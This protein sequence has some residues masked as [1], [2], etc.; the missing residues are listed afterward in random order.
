[1]L[2]PTELRLAA[3]YVQPDVDG[4]LRDHLLAEANHIDTVGRMD[5]VKILSGTCV[6]A[7]VGGWRTLMVA[8]DG[9]AVDGGRIIPLW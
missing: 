2:T 5:L 7:D 1:M 6:A 9:H 3:S 8:L 4:D